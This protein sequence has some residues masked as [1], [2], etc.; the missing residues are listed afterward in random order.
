MSGSPVIEPG[1]EL[2]E[3]QRIL[4]LPRREPLNCEPNKETKRWLPEVEALID[5]VTAKYTRGPRLSCACRER[6]VI[7]Y[8]GGVID[9]FQRGAPGRP[10]PLPVRMTVDAF[11]QD[12]AHDL[13]VC[14]K[15]RALKP[16]DAIDLPGM[17]RPCIK[18][19][20]AIQAW[21]LWELEQTGGV[22]GF[23][24]IGAGK[25]LAAGNEIFDLRTAQ[26]RDINR[27][28]FL[29]VPSLGSDQRITGRESL[30][31]PSGR[32]VCR[33][34][35]LADG[36]E[37]VASND[38]PI[39]TARG[40]LKV[41]DVQIRDLV[42]VASSVPSPETPTEI[43]DDELKLVAY[44]LSDG[45]CN[46][47]T[48]TFTNETPLVLAEFETLVRTVCGGFSE[49]KSRSNARELRLLKS[50][51]FRN[52]W[53]LYGLAKN[54]RL[55][56]SLWG[57]SQRQ[58]G[59]FL[60][61]F[62]AC[63]GY[64][65]KGSRLAIILAS[66][67]MIDDLQFLLLRLGVRARKKYKRSSYKKDGQ[68]HSFDSW[69]LTVPTCDAERFLLHVGDVLG[70]EESCQRVRR[71]LATTVRNTNVDIVPI[72]AKQ[73]V[74]IC[75]ELGMPRSKLAR[76]ERSA[77]TRGYLKCAYHQ[78]VSRQA[79]ID[80]CKMYSYTG[81]YSG[82]ASEDLRWERV[83][84]NIDV[85]VKDVFDL[86]VPET[87]NFVV[88]AGMIVHNTLA[89]FAATLALPQCKTAVLLAKPDQRFHYRQHY[90][91]FREHFRVP[92]LVLDK[93][94]DHNDRLFVEG[95]PVAHFIPY[96][97]LQNRKS[98]DILDQIK[99]DIII[100]DEGHCL[101][102]QPCLKR[103]GSTR[104]M[105]FL[106]Y[107][108][109]H[110]G[111]HFAVWSGSL[112][113]KSLLDVT[114]LSAHSL[115]LGSP[116]PIISKDVDAWSAVIDPSYQPDTKSPTAK[117]LRKA[118][119]GR[120]GHESPVAA[121]VAD[122]HVR[123]G[124]REHARR[125]PGVI[126]TSALAVNT[127]ITIHRRDPPALPEMVQMAL[128]P[129]RELW[130]RPDGEELA[131]AM[132][133]A[134]CAREV[135]AGYY[136]RFVYPDGEPPELIAEWFEAR[137]NFN[138]E[139][140]RMLQQGHLHLDSK[141]LLENAAERAYRVPRYDGPL[142]VWTAD[143]WLPWL[144]I[145]DKVRPVSKA[146]WIDDFLAR[147]AAAWATENTGIVWYQSTTF[148]ERVAKLAGIN[149]HRG[150]D[151]AEARI[152]AENGKKSIV[153]SISAHGEGRDGLQFNFSKQLVAEIP[154]SG[155]GW[156]QILGRLAR[157]GQVEDQVDTWVFVHTPENRDALRKA[158]SFAEFDEDMAINRS[159]LLAAD[160]SFDL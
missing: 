32:K 109:E 36:T 139:I 137:K 120:T 134:Q 160:F 74:E 62:W 68:T 96:S 119:G 117:A 42:A 112:I 53:N 132:D 90:L 17:N 138:R 102:A 78:Y 20:N 57:L 156:D 39:L 54:K 30:C 127:S 63:D 85:G 97:L 145:R 124:L 18:R 31:F 152:L 110:E 88:N 73:I 56:P 66:E 22:L 86:S 29:L 129:L 108:E 59:L 79:F 33:R 133:Q 21:I 103:Q 27:G 45:G 67:K 121:L 114:H 49:A 5:V 81:K 104:A 142:P 10:P 130:K 140:R 28:G 149:L 11:C 69:R 75:D 159:L 46:N 89:A 37:V 1:S 136:H 105:R 98:T 143:S 94:I 111:T 6:H 95:A 83:N 7:A 115:G 126:S 52:R 158:I 123:V 64:I 40:W 82:F 92:S 100:A 14:K 125:T 113:N 77:V 141:A 35:I 19:F 122:D 44:M 146:V 25:C 106:R 101:S 61:R 26:R 58:I 4:A 128:G 107:M 71:Y 151:G 43:S 8:A 9:V 55:H 72:S 16:G 148:G 12:S 154:S 41:E 80:F 147:D 116:Y 13:P 23:V 99:P 50:R 87:H 91:H 38:H 84:V 93:T 2:S 48:A 155:K 34:V 131:E 144:A 60:N 47:V 24:P 65:E 70:K 157:K 135:G 150:G 118:F 3:I 51:S 76:G 153:A 15:V